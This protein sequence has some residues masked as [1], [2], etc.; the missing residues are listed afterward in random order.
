MADITA[1]M[2][3]EL[4]EKTGAG[5]M[6]AKNALVECNGDMEASIDWLRTKGLAKA[7]KKSGRTA[8]EGLVAISS[9]ENGLE[10]SL[11]EIN[12]ET[13]F[14]GRN[15]QFQSFVKKAASLALTTDGS[16]ESLANAA[17]EAGKNTAEA[18]TALIAT[19][20]ENMS[21]RRSTKLSVSQG[22]V[23][24]YVHNAIAP[25]LGKIGVLVALESAAPV[26]TLQTLGKQLAMHVAAAAPEFLDAA[27]VDPAAAEREKNVQRETA[28]A[29]GKPAEI[30][31]KMLEG[32]MRK[33]FEEVCLMDQSFIMDPETK[34]AAL[35]EKAG[36]EAGSPIKLIAF[37]RFVLGEGIE[38]EETDFAA[39]VAAAVNG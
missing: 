3:K 31:E 34:I 27:S 29:S 36:K 2:V 21:L 10:A 19:I 11:V 5:M 4:R 16:T 15:E 22:Y 1:S 14:V 28:L 6:D 39:E 30:V 33:Y 35:L 37:S 17:F 7:A 9:S 8:A 38:K 26:E 23:A 25:N 12:A 32:R 24:S 20:G 13:D 18:L